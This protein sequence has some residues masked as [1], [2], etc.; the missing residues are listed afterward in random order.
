MTLSATNP[1]VQVR[2]LEAHNAFKAFHKVDGMAQ[3]DKA[4]KLSSEAE[5][6]V[7]AEMAVIQSKTRTFLV[8]AQGKDLFRDENG[9]FSPCEDKARAITMFVQRVGIVRIPFFVRPFKQKAQIVGHYAGKTLQVA[10]SILSIVAIGRMVYKPASAAFA[11][12]TSIS[13]FQTLTFGSPT[14]VGGGHF[15]NSDIASLAIP[16]VT[17]RALAFEPFIDFR[18]HDEV[19]EFHGPTEKQYQEAKDNINNGDASWHD[20]ET[21]YDWES[22]N[23]S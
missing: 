13:A 18:I 15:S 2:L 10:N 9:K 7:Y 3:F 16:N 21:T 14:V 5:N 20:Y 1:K 12:R 8:I 23:I 6:G 22:K 17:A 4:V 19:R 11:S